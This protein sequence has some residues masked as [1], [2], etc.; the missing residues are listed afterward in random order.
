MNLHFDDYL[1]PLVAIFSFLVLLKW[2]L[3]KD[4]TLSLLDLVCTDG[5]LN[6][7]KVARM[8][9]WIV[10]SLGFYTLSVHSPEQLNAYAPLYGALWVSSAAI[11]KWQRQKELDHANPPPK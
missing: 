10:M 1:Y 5:K 4:N 8:G 3:A 9:S 7:R 6:D 11:D 2:H